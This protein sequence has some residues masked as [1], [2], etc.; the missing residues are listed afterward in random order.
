LAEKQWLKGAKT[1]VGVVSIAKPG[2]RVT[3]SHA[4]VVRTCLND[5]AS[6]PLSTQFFSGL[7]FD[8]AQPVSAVETSGLSGAETYPS[9]VTSDF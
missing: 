8:V 9:S 3:I 4:M 1:K 7:G 6:T 5:R 2:F